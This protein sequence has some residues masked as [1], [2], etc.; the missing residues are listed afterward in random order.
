MGHQ[1][2][3]VAHVHVTLWCILGFACAS[4]RETE[5]STTSDSADAA[6][7]VEP[8]SKRS[9][10]TAASRQAGDAGIPATMSMRADEA[11]ET[12]SDAASDLPKEPDHDS[13][14]EHTPEDSP[15]DAGA[16]DA[17]ESTPDAGAPKEDSTP[18]C[19]PCGDHA[20]CD[21]SGER[22]E[23][24]CDQ[25]FERDGSACTDIDECASG[26]SDCAEQA[27]CVN[28]V[29]GFHCECNAGFQGDGTQCEDVDE[30]A[31]DAQCAAEANCVNEPGGYRCECRAGFEGDGKQCADVDECERG[32]AECD[33]AAACG[34]TEGSY[35]CTCG[36]GFTGDGRTCVDI[37]ECA[38]EATGCHTNASCVNAPGSFMCVC[39]PG[40]AGDGIDC[41]DIDECESGSDDCDNNAR[42]TNAAG[43]FSCACNAGF[44]GDGKQCADVDE[45]A[46]GTDNCGSYAVCANTVGGFSCTCLE[47]YEA[48]SGACADV[49]ECARGTTDCAEEAI[50]TNTPG[51]FQCAC[52]PGYAG[53][54]ITCTPDEVDECALGTANCD[55]NATCTNTR[56]SFRCACNSGYDGDGVTCA[57]VDECA[58][59]DDNCS[60]RAS[61]RNV[62]GSFVCTCEPGYEGDGVTC[63][64]RVDSCDL[65]GTFG[66]RM[67]LD[68]EWDAVRIAGLTA[69]Q[70]GSQTLSSWSLRRQTHDGTTIRTETQ[71]CGEDWPQLC[72]QLLSLA[73]TQEVPVS[74][75]SRS[76]MPRTTSTFELDG[77]AVIGSS[78]TSALE[79]RILGLSLG[80]P[81]MTWPSSYDDA[82]ITWLDH[83]GDGHP[84]ITGIVPQ[85]G[86][87]SRCGFPYSPLPIPATF[88]LVQS[89]YQGTRLQTQLDGRIVDCD[90]IEG[91]V[92][93]P[94]GGPPV[95]DVHVIGCDKIEGGGECTPQ[96][97]VSLD[98]TV[99]NIQDIVAARFVA[100]RVPDNTT[101]EQLRA[102]QFP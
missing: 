6:A 69:I 13:S 82:A 33:A 86:S 55:D 9:T 95:L 32:G 47:G 31:S 40:Y 11:D 85:S 77:P 28:D 64:E 88:E 87:S 27:T 73:F 58:T 39:N 90:T 89:L 23:C 60:P 93:G 74:A 78:V 43:G 22:A 91:D 59:G 62:A 44:S 99:V 15:S 18:R 12:A 75:Y 49:D 50:C 16:A 30:C 53:D 24:R 63:S 26:A 4:D 10:Q 36:D 52:G 17:S 67:E 81:A 94:R 3:L 97:I 42:C 20:T 37:D 72:S 101:C 8:K 65:S 83:D 71:A 98:E 25:G 14:E 96:E 57:D 41:R 48:T 100:V 80:D 102:R 66:V 38:A 46:T 1:M 92:R 35:T 76:G 2:R 21:T 34:N 7:N 51:G 5:A 70:G 84:G 29:G 61:C 56:E 19:E 79:R 54:G 45:C 68:I